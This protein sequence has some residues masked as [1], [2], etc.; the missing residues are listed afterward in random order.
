MGCGYDQ[1]WNSNHKLHKFGLSSKNEKFCSQYG[2]VGEWGCKNA[3]WWNPLN[4]IS[5]IIYSIPLPLHNRLITHSTTIQPIRKIRSPRVATCWVA[6]MENHKT[7]QPIACQLKMRPLLNRQIFGVP[8]F[9]T[10]LKAPRSKGPIHEALAQ[11]FSDI[12]VCEKMTKILCPNRYAIQ[13]VYSSYTHHC[14]LKHLHPILA[15]NN[16]L[17]ACRFPCLPIFHDIMAQDGETYE[18]SRTFGI[19]KPTY[20]SGGSHNVG[21]IY[22]YTYIYMYLYIYIYIY[23]ML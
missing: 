16:P 8:N 5:I 14:M 11:T 6:T 19:C 12:F 1:W 4:G 2:F 21:I 22:I 23:Q 17:F 20:N 3:N 10:S 18:A 15:A 9:Q 7:L 13:P